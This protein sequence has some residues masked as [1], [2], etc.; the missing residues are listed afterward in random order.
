MSQKDITLRQGHATPATIILR[1]L[2]AAP[3]S[4]TTTIYLYE[5]HASPKTVVL[6]DPTTVRVAA[7]AQTYT[8][9]GDVALTFAV[10]ADV[11]FGDVQ[12]ADVA[13]ALAVESPQTATY[14]EPV[15][16]AVTFG[17]AAT[18]TATFAV[19]GDVV[20]SFDVS[21]AFEYVAGVTPE[22]EPEPQ[23]PAPSGGGGFG[24]GG[25]RSRKPFKVPAAP[26]RAYVFKGNAWFAP[27]WEPRSPWSVSRALPAFAQASAFT[28]DSSVSATYAEPSRA[29]IPLTNSA[30]MAFA[31]TP[32]LD[33]WLIIDPDDWLGAILNEEE[34]ALG[35]VP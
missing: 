33:E 1:A 29:A 2:E 9:T 12:P 21:S 7:G 26:P 20:L 4:P 13:L 23:A 30:P 27:G 28:T 25:P 31:V 5:F 34:L 10:T 22:P 24:G 11:D 15:D 35:G 17:V 16:V 6:G 14:A 19:P 3:P 32:Q 18:Q 8:F